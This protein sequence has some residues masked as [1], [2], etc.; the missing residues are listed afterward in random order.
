MP[1]MRTLTAHMATVAGVIWYWVLVTW[2]A[3]RHSNRCRDPAAT[4]STAITA[5][6]VV[7]SSSWRE[8]CSE[9]T[10]YT[11]VGFVVP[12]WDAKVA[13]GRAGGRQEA[14]QRAELSVR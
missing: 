4:A 8:Q 2:M 9:A 7:S 3:T 12:R 14:G 13:R 5:S 6:C 10:H 11:P 1:T